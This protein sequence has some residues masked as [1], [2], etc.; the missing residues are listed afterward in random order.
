MLSTDIANFAFVTHK[1]HR[2]KLLTSE[3]AAILLH[4][5]PDRKRQ[6]VATTKGSIANELIMA[7]RTFIVNPE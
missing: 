6:W 7:R 4:V 3:L 2:G 5:L 1:R